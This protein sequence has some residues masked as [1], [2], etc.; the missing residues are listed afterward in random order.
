MIPNPKRRTPSASEPEPNPS[1]R[2]HGDSYSDVLAHDDDLATNASSHVP[3]ASRR[4]EEP[5][6]TPLDDPERLDS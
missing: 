3:S 5:A 4:P 6:D 1:R 2:Q